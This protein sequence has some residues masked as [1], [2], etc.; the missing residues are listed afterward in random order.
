MDS[1]IHF[2]ENANTADEVPISQ[3]IGPG[4]VIDVSAHSAE[5]ADYLVMP[6]DIEAFEAE[7][8]AI[9]AGAIVLLNNNR[10]RFYPD[11]KAYM[12]T[13]ERGQAAVQKLHFPGLV[14]RQRRCWWRARSGRSALTRPPS[15]MASPRTSQPM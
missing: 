1:P 12:G 4:Y 11:R 14:W 10:A 7:H 13:D 3:L 15:T 8:G 5:N 6:A 2:A 9:P